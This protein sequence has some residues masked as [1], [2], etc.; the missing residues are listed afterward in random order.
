MTAASGVLDALWCGIVATLAADLWQRLLQ[1]LAGLPAAPWGLVGRWVALMPRGVFAHRSIAAAPPVQGERAL[2]WAFHYLVGMV[3]AALYLALLRWLGATPSLSSAVLFSLALLA[4]PWFV[5]Q[6][7]LGFG[8]FAARTPRPNVTRAVNVS[9][10][11]AFGIGLFVG[12]VAS[13]F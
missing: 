9:T 3:Y 7:A 4:A 10:H 1:A 13:P 11:A 12:A 2:G 8:V 5:M 6:P